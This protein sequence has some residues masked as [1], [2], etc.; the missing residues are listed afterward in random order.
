[1]IACTTTNNKTEQENSEMKPDIFAGDNSQNSLD[2]AGTYVGTLP[3]ADCAGIETRITLD[4]E[5][6]YTIQ[7]SYLEKGTGEKF[8]TEGNFKW[9]KTGGKITLENING[10]S[11]N[12]YLV[13]ENKLFQLDLNGNK[14]KGDLESN[15]VLGK[16]DTYITGKKW[17]LIEINGQPIDTSNNQLK[18]G[19]ITLQNGSSQVTG[20]GTC[21]RF[22]G[23]YTLDVNSQ[24]SFSKMGATR[25]ACPDMNTERAFM[26]LLELVDSY[27]IKN[28]ILT[29]HNA[30]M[31]P[32]A[33]FS[34]R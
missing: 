14:I 23:S 2:W 11:P 16:I 29:F 4:N 22:N 26:Q 17:H 25:M 12:H 34:T 32:L 5:E 3:C 13:G 7:T 10:D 8:Q 33:K 9:D 24:L 18:Q 1:M 15:Y 27:V 21:N 28:D 31:A 19:Y 20:H 6:K 30:K